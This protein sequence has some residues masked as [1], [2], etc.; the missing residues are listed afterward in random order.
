MEITWPQQGVYV[1]QTALWNQALFQNGN[2][3]TT[4]LPNFRAFLE[5]F[6]SSGTPSGGDGTS[7]C[8]QGAELPTADAAGDQ[9]PSPSGDLIVDDSGTVNSATGLFELSATI[10]P[11]VSQMLVEY[12]IDLS[13]PLKPVLEEKGRTPTDDEYLYLLG[14]DVA[15]AYDG[16]TYKASWDQNFYFLNISGTDTF[17]ALYV[18]DQGDG[19][20][21]IPAMY[22]PEENR[23]DVA[24][25]QFMDFLFFNFDYWIEQGARFS[26]VQFSV[27]ETEGRINDNLSLFT[28]NAAGVYTEQPRSA[29]GYLIPIVYIDAFIQGRQLTKLPGGF[30]QTV[31]PWTETVSYNV[32][33][34]PALNI[35]NVIPSTDAVVINMYAYDHGNA[36]RKPD[37]RRYDVKRERS[38]LPGSLALETADEAAGAGASAAPRWL[39][40]R[41]GFTAGMGFFL[42]GLL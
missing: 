33:K 22:F 8:G 10:A 15:G 12:G 30:N 25:L 5:W 41:V 36:T 28:S 38:A 34:T 1:S 23:E 24:G 16:N 37:V 13:T 26:F 2:Y 35:F 29:G 42:S 17:E 6:L 39:S 3:I 9:L 14:G 4:I 20:R 40:Y 19:S 32:L 7:V 21:K 18:F 11:A 31:I 27:N